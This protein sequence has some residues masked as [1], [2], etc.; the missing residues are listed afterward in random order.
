[1]K[2]KILQHS[3]FLFLF[4]LDGFYPTFQFLEKSSQ[5]FDFVSLFLEGSHLV[6]L[7]EQEQD[8]FASIN[9]FLVFQTLDFVLE[10]S[11]HTSLKDKKQSLDSNRV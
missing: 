4:L 8:I 5:D 3:L 10:M 2:Q 11:S 9:E 1:M 7:Q 6:S